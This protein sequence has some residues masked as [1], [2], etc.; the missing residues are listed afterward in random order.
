MLQYHRKH[1]NAVMFNQTYHAAPPQHVYDPPTRHQNLILD[2][3]S[4]NLTP[5]TPLNLHP[6]T[7]PSIDLA[8]YAMPMIH[9]VTG[10]TISIYCK[11]IKDPATTEIWMTAFR[12]DFGGMSQG[13]NKTGQKGS[14]AMFVMS[15]SNITQIS[16]DHIITY[17]RVVVDHRS[18]KEDPNRI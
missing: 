3:L 18:Q 14:N 1:Q 7:S 10:V 15:P 4:R 2:E 17:A 6:N 5:Y 13:S 12:K 11:L 9:P 8:H 16:K